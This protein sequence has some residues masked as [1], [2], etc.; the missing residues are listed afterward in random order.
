MSGAGTT[1]P[2][3]FDSQTVFTAAGST[4]VVITVTAVGQRLLPKLMGWDHSTMRS[5]AASAIRTPRRVGQAKSL[6]CAS[7][8]ADRAIMGRPPAPASHARPGVPD[9]AW[10][11]R[12][13]WWRSGRGDP[14]LPE[15]VAPP[16][17]SHHRILKVVVTGMALAALRARSHLFDSC[18]P[19]CCRYRSVPRVPLVLR[20]PSSRHRSSMVG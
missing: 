11:H 8:T 3:W 12:A 15:A 13:A 20:T 14:A 1:L 19:P 5:R 9:L 17:G 7:V 4:T 2:Q 6:S 16:A 18:Y 10:R